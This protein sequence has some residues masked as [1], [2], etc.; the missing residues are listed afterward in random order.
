MPTLLLLFGDI[1]SEIAFRR[2]AIGAHFNALRFFA[3]WLFPFCLRDVFRGRGLGKWIVG[4]RVVDAAEPERPA[5]LAQ[6][7]LRNLT[8]WLSPVGFFAAASHPDKMRFGDRLANTMVV[9]E[10]YDPMSSVWVRALFRGIVI[11]VM[12]LAALF[13]YLWGLIPYAR[14]SQAHA[15]TVDWLN[16][17]E[18]LAEPFDLLG[19]DAGRM[20]VT[21]GRFDI[22]DDGA[23]VLLVYA[24][25]VEAGSGCQFRV[26]LR[27]DFA[28]DKG[29]EVR[30]ASGLL[31]SRWQE[32]EHR[33]MF[34]LRLDKNLHRFLTEEEIDRIVEKKEPA[35]TVLPELKEEDAKE[36]RDADKHKKD[37]SKTSEP[38]AEAPATKAAPE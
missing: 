6:Q 38:D 30:Q 3:I 23:E 27:Q 25:G 13:S 28:E 19:I 21:L 2:T 14:N 18:Y 10:A 1:D 17:R 16:S 35:K 9:D 34:F 36:E 12:V 22:V 11:V 37:A 24:Y 32:K 8:I 20:F 29:W 15:F 26:V 4:I 31:V 5:S 33:R 7:L